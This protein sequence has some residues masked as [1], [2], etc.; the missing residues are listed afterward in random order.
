M[1]KTSAQSGT[2]VR[3]LRKGD[4]DFYFADGMV[5]YPRAGFEISV[6]CP[7]RYQEILVEAFEKG[8]IRPVAYMKESEYVWDQLQQDR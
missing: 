4:S 1:I 7:V 2:L 3:E 6:M 5:Q 8:W